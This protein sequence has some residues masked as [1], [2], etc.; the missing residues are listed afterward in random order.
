MSKFN[1][2]D[3]VRGEVQ[4]IQGFREKPKKIGAL[5]FFAIRTGRAIKLSLAEPEI[6]LFSILQWIVIGLA[7]YLWVQMLGWIPEEVW[8]SAS[9]SDSGS[10]AD[11]VLFVWSFLVVGLAAF[12]L[13]ILSAC[14]GAVHFLKRA[15]QPSTIASCLRMV[16]P[17]VG[18]LWAF[19]WADGWITVGQIMERLPKK[20]NWPP[21][22]ASEALYYA[23]KVGTM[24]VMPA[25][26]TGRNLV[27]AGKES[28]SFL[29]HKIVDAALLRVGYSLVCWVVGISAY[30]GTIL[31]FI[32]FDV[33]P[34]GEVYSF[35]FLFYLWAGIPLLIAVGIVLLFIRPVYL[36]ALSDIYSD[37]LQE[38]Q[39]P[40]QVPVPAPRIVS[41]LVVFVI[42]AAFIATAYLFRS[43][44]GIMDLLATPYKIEPQD[45]P[46]TVEAYAAMTTTQEVA[47][48]CAKE[49][50]NLQGSPSWWNKGV[51]QAGS[52]VCE[53]ESAVWKELPG[54]W[55]YLKIVDA[56][57]SDG[58]FVFGMRDGVGNYVFC[59]EQWCALRDAAG[60]TTILSTTPTPVFA[61]TTLPESGTVR[62]GEKVAV[63]QLTTTNTTDEPVDL[64]AL[65]YKKSGTATD[66]AIGMVYV[67]E[68]GYG[69]GMSHEHGLKFA[70]DGMV[71]INQ[72][73]MFT[74]APKQSRTYILQIELSDTAGTEAG[75]SIGLEL[76]GF[77][78]GTH[79]TGMP[80]IGTLHTIA[81]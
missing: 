65:W 18:A 72:P 9:N 42:L 15:G 61:T 24:G 68:L 35:V 54:R 69:F 39:L 8:R 63:V 17:R 66:A 25:L 78:Y 75:K 36:I 31:F 47:L 20:R 49:A 59:G 45:S 64:V 33:L 30:I 10:V 27:D 55:K 6:L 12:P 13:G 3:F 60:G 2:L 22:T 26:I 11:I 48:K 57:V 4:G 81:P 44:L 43:G 62:P 74:L 51:P 28:V 5:K 32:T 77:A 76:M 67:E 41:V 23:W 21:S 40:A 38:Q 29:R 34:S 14:I 80:V 53:R 1:Q 73:D 56:D 7:Y 70:S 37:Y 16:L 79:V 50:S 19:S 52:V 71:Y 58:T 46:I